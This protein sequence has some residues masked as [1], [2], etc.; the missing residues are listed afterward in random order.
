MKLQQGNSNS[1][2]NDL[3]ELFGLNAGYVV[4]LYERYLRDPAAVSP[5]M[6]A[7][8][9]RLA[10]GD[11]LA[12]AETPP[13]PTAATPFTIDTIVG[14]SNLSRAIRSFG[15]LAADLSPLGALPPGDP[16]LD[17]GTYG[18]TEHDLRQLPA[19]IVGGPVAEGAAN[20][21]DAIAR[22]RAIYCRTTGYEFR[23]IQ[24]NAERRWLTSAVE[25][26]RFA[27]PNEPLDRKAVLEQL[28]QVEAFERFLHRTFP[29]QKRFSIEGLDV[30]VPMLLEFIGAAAETGIHSTWIG[31]AHRGR[32]SVLASILGKPLAEIFEKFSSAAKSVPPSGVEDVGHTGDVTYHLGARTAYPTS[33]TVE[34]LVTL[35]PNPSHLEYVDPVVEGMCRAADEQRKLPGFP[36]QDEDKSVVVL[37]HGDA[38]FAGEGIVAETLNMSRLDGY[39][40]GGTVHIIANNELGFTTPPSAGRGTLYASDLAKGFEI[41][42]VHVNADDPEACIAAIRLAQA[43]RQTFHKDFLVDLV[44]YRRWGHNEAEEPTFTQPVLYARVKNHPTVRAIWASRLER[45]GEITPDEA[46]RLLRENLDKLQAAYNAFKTAPPPEPTP[47]PL[48]TIRPDD[49]VTAVP[50]DR[51]LRLNRGLTDTPPDFTINPKLTRWLERRQEALNPSG[52][53]DWAHA[54]SLAFASLLAEGTPIRLTGQDVARGTFSQRHLVLH[55]AQNGRS[56]SP[57][58]TLPEARA[59]FAVYD[60]PL[61]EAGPLGFEYGYSSQARDTL[62]LWEAQFGDFANVAQVIIDQ[63]MAAGQAKWGQTSGLVVLLPHAL[64]G[65]GPEH[66]SGRP[67]RFLQLAAQDN[68]QLV[69]CTTAGQYFHVLRRQAALLHHLPRPLVIF[70]PKSLLRHPLAASTLADLAH[71]KFRPVLDDARARQHPH[72]ISRVVLCTGH[73]YVDLAESPI[74]AERDDLALVRV[75]QLYPFPSDDLKEVLDGYPRL[76]EVIW[77]QEEPANMGAWSFVAWPIAEL[78]PENVQLTY[79]GRSPRAAPAVGAHHVYSAEQAQL[80]RAALGRLDEEATVFGIEVRKEVRNGSGNPRSPVGGVPGRSDGRS[81]ARQGG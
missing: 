41:P 44:G 75:E 73:G 68:L 64:E 53:I 40:T 28:S 15:H 31:M 49:V 3:D 69:N 57:L 42:I 48:P 9:G 36:S 4:E 61:A 60:S 80:V 29:G 78:L 43:Y 72:K 58:Q 54:E 30:L 34:M 62:V 33:R 27:D 17:L 12:E 51:L 39:R 81:L 63:F 45:D 7:W 11:V 67:E 21:W 32:L 55:D 24:S 22:L 5:Q 13:R 46:E 18:L 35:A 14:A 52:E 71:G 65:M 8:F 23:H 74:Y 70:T 56:Y 59:S 16:A 10:P 50:E 25:T 38:A 76:Q 47:E 26:C 1:R 20:A 66:S 79:V 77:A 19:R 2:I 37:V 6:R